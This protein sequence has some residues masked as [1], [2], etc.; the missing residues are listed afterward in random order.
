MFGS[1][2]QTNKIT[3]FLQKIVLS[4]RSVVVNL[5]Q[6]GKSRVFDLNTSRDEN[7]PGKSRPSQRSA[8][9]ARLLL[10]RCRSRI[11]REQF[12]RFQRFYPESQGQNL[13][14]TVLCVPYSLDSGDAGGRGLAGLLAC[15]TVDYDPCIENQLVSRNQLWGLMWCK[16]SERERERESARE[17]EQVTRPRMKRT[18]YEA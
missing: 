4:E 5:V 12:E 6:S 13:A 18:G 9:P 14:L 17:R 3:T 2:P 8:T 16:E 1:S 11:E 15:H 7:G 10:S